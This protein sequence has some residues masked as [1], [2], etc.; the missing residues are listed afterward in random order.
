MFDS[1]IKSFPAD[2]PRLGIGGAEVLA[3][4]LARPRATLATESCADR[5]CADLQKKTW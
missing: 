4:G 3:T 5:S 1:Q 2:L